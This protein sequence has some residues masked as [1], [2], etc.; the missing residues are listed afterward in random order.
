[1]GG[2]GWTGGL[3]DQAPRPEDPDHTPGRGPGLEI[4]SLALEVRRRQQ[5]R[6]WLWVPELVI[7][8][9]TAQR[10]GCAD[11]A[12]LIESWLRPY[13]GQDAVLG[14]GIVSFG[15]VERALALLAVAR[16]DDGR[17][18]ALFTEAR[19]RTERGGALA[20]SRQIDADLSRLGLGWGPAPEGPDP[21]PS[22]G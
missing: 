9:E 17:A 12:T 15:P 6:D 14:S 5:A 8:A 10:V 18:A 3:E 4:L 20:W 13:T 19:E 11:E 1:M 22:V 2:A 21:A 7:A 16:G